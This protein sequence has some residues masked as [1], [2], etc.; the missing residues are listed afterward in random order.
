[1]GAVASR[2]TGVSIVYS[3]VCSGA[4][5]KKHQ[6]FAS[7]AF[8]KGIHRYP[9]N[10]PHKGPD[11]EMFPFDD[12]IMEHPPSDSWKNYLVYTSRILF[13]FCKT[14]TVCLDVKNILG[15]RHLLLK[16]E[17]TWK[18]VIAYIISVLLYSALSLR[19]GTKL[20][21]EVY[22]RINHPFPFVL[23]LF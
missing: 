7:L 23:W 11:G 15:Y 16:N 18:P 12:V 1:M 4:D 5:Q 6:S 22:G 14:D 17:I 19:L 3:T 21:S 8:V 10:S 20:I 13:I 9:V 2:I